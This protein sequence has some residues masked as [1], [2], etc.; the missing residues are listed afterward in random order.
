[1]KSLSIVF[2]ESLFVCWLALSGCTSDE[3]L[4]RNRLGANEGK[5]TERCLICR[6]ANMLLPRVRLIGAECLDDAI[7]RIA[8]VADEDVRIVFEDELSGRSVN[9]FDAE[10]ITMLETLALFCR[11]NGLALLT[12]GMD[13][14]YVF[15]RGALTSREPC[16]K[17]PCN[18]KRT[19]GVFRHSGCLNE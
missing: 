9:G 4:N 18:G 13:T 5:A 17:S 10:N 2:R 6:S 3:G 7:A 15:E 16:G 12:D 11:S 8:S 1:M 14:F 19:H